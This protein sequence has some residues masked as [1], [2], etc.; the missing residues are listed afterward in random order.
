MSVSNE[1]VSSRWFLPQD[2]H[3]QL[4][5]TV[6]QSLPADRQVVNARIERVGDVEMAPYAPPGTATFVSGNN[7]SWN[8]WNQSFRITVSTTD[9]TATTVPWITWNQNYGTTITATTT[10]AWANWNNGLTIQTIPAPLNAYNPPQ[11]TA[12][13]RTQREAVERARQEAYQRQCAADRAKRTAADERAEALLHSVLSEEQVHMLTREGRFLVETK[14]GRVYEIKRGYQH[15]V[16]LL[17]RDRKT[18][19]QELCGHVRKGSA[20]PVADHMVAQYLYLLQHEDEFRKV[21]NIWD[22]RGQ[23]VVGSH[24]GVASPVDERILEVAA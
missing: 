22:L 9:A 11:E 20:M 5:R 13:A 21:C 19:V 17:G 10:N 2:V 12:Q 24:S 15:N 8:H 23:K 18:R 16:F 3:D 7:Q 4:V 6:A 14:G 1:A